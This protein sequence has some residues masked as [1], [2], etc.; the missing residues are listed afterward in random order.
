MI[1]SVVPDTNVLIKGMI[2]YKSPHRQLLNLAAAKKLVLYGCVETNDE[3][4]EK[5]RIKRLKR[6]WETKL[7]SPEKL[8]LDYKGVIS[9]R[10]VDSESKSLVINLRDPD[11][12]VFI[13]LAK[14]VGAKIIISEDEDLLS[15]RNYGEITIVTC[16]EFLGVISKHL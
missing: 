6:Y 12:E 14:T 10:E 16:E 15:L 8:E 5:I 2:G 3:F 1:I 9:L 11:D 7:F 4:K 13:R